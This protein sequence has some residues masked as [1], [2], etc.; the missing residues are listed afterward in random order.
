MSDS[1]TFQTLA[2]ILQNEHRVDPARIRPETALADLGLDSLALME[3]VF[4]AEDA[5]RL[6]LPEDQLDPR[7]AGITLGELC[8]AIERFAAGQRETEEAAP[9]RAAHA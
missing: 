5:L 4:S 2:Q 7:A 9:G 6:R 1:I 3:F 8:E